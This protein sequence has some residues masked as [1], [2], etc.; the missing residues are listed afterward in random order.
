MPYDPEDEAGWDAL[1]A[2][3]EDEKEAVTDNIGPLHTGEDPFVYKLQHIGDRT[4]R[5]ASQPEKV[6]RRADRKKCC[7][8]MFSNS[9]DLAT[10]LVMLLCA[11]FAGT[12]LPDLAFCNVPV[13]ICR[14]ARSATARVL[15]GFAS[16]RCCALH[17]W[18]LVCCVSVKHPG[19][20]QGCLACLTCS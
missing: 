6:G 20:R 18:T 17:S 16:C 10:S 15:E 11:M 14:T 1:P 3:S 19:W 8:F 2:V 7:R 4:L 9:I 12:Q 13:C 5:L